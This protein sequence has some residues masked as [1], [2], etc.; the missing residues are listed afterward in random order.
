MLDS[1]AF[2]Q[3]RDPLVAEWCAIVGLDLLWAT[4]LADDVVLDER[5]DVVGVLIWH[6]LRD[7]PLGEVIHGDQEVA[8]SA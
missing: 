6:G 3:F 7:W 5:G 1:A 2:C 4:V 8:I